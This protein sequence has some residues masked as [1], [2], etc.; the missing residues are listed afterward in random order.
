MPASRAFSL[1]DIDE[2]SR[3]VA[4]VASTRAPVKMLAQEGDAMVERLEALESWDLEAFRA[5]PIVLWGHDHNLPI[6]RA[7]DIRETERGLEMRIHFET[8]DDSE[9]IWQ[10]VRRKL[11]RGV[12]VGYDLGQR[13]DEQRDGQAVA[14]F[15]GNKLF[16]TSVV[17]VPADPGGLVKQGDQPRTD[18]DAVVCRFDYVGTLGKLERTQ[19][20]GIKAPARI[21]RTGILEYRFPDGSVRR[22]LR[23]PE[24]VFNADSLKSLSGATVCDLAHHLRGLIDT[25]RWKDATLGHVESVRQDGNYVAAVLNINDARAVVDAENKRLHDISCGY[26]CK[27]D[28]SPGEYQGQPY[29]AIQRGIRYNHVAVLPKGKGRAGTDVALRLDAKDAVCVEAI[30]PVESKHM[31]TE[32]TKRVIRIDGKDLEYGSE[33]HINHLETV[34]LADIAKFGKEKAELQT[35]LDAAEGAANAAETRAKKA[36]DDL[37]DEID[38]EGEKAKT[39]AAKQKT[40]E[41]LL[42]RAIRALVTEEDDEEEET[43]TDALED[44][45]AALSDKDIMLKVIRSD[46]AYAEDKTLDAR[47]EAYIQAIF[48]ALNKRGVTRADGVDHV[49]R[50]AERIKR[51]D[52]KEDANDP[53][54]KARKE[55]DDRNA[56]RWQQPLGVTK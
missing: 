17:T 29:D 19:V 50:T 3:S 33:A 45:L 36:E 55:R 46:A 24:E 53:V 43:K 35:K 52:A 12:S 4:V 49:V 44:E 2:G 32:N 30:Q 18:A 51:L 47:P 54:V 25:H 6:G 28:F 5:N 1:G 40:R 22:E 48:D 37:K 15:T 21:T 16:E 56:K 34:H 31:T 23:L 9:R 10:K 41:R 11:V 39:K 42:R 20:G 26:T 14:V 7:S 38:P 13:R 27:L 8:D